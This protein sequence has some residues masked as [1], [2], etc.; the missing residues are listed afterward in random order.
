MLQ[1]KYTEVLQG[2]DRLELCVNKWHRLLPDCQSSN[3]MQERAGLSR[4][5]WAIYK[6]IAKSKLPLGPHSGDLRAAVAPF[7]ANESVGGT[8]PFT[9]F[10]DLQIYW[11]HGCRILFDQEL[12]AAAYLA[13][14]HQENHLLLVAP[15]GQ[16]CQK[17]F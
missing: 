8:F 9:T 11:V 13:L 5:K 6:D 1:M 10:A 2:F 15:Y 4:E 17:F 7:L 12:A 3:A 14:H 16:F